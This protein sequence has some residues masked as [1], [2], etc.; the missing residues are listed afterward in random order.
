MSRKKLIKKVE[1]ITD[2]KYSEYD[3]LIKLDSVYKD[4]EKKVLGDKEKRDALIQEVNDQTRFNRWIM[5]V[6]FIWALVNYY[7]M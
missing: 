5:F 7:T 2:K 3:F 6:L 1:E 4:M